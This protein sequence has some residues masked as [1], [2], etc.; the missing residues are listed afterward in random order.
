MQRRVGIEQPIA[1]AQ[2]VNRYR[3][4]SEDTSDR[5]WLTF[6]NWAAIDHQCRVIAN[7]SVFGRSR[8]ISKDYAVTPGLPL[9]TAGRP[10][11]LIV[12]GSL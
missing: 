12:S 6:K 5:L 3:V 4:Q 1:S 11:L 10:K 9:H 8:R 2:L 7:P